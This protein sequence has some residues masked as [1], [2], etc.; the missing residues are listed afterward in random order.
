VSRAAVDSSGD[1]QGTPGHTD[2]TSN[3]FVTLLTSDSYLPGALAALSSLL[4]AEGKTQAG[5]FQTVC[6][7][8]PTTVSAESIR[9]LRRAFDMTV[10]VEEIRSASLKELSLLGKSVALQ[11]SHVIAI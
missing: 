4:D 11:S 9:T 6:L 3:A 5:L 7:V 8:T 1:T 10:A 2:M